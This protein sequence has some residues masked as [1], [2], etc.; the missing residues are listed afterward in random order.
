MKAHILFASLA[1]IVALGCAQLRAADVLPPGEAEAKARLNSSPRHGEWVDIAVPGSKTPLKSWIVYPEVKEKAPVVIVIH[2]IFG[3]SD[4]IRAVADQLAAEGFIAIAP[5]LLSGHGKDGGGTDS[6]AGRDDVTKAIRG[7]KTDEVMADLDAV[8]A[9]G[10]K[11]PASNGK[12]ACVGFCWGGGQ[13]FAYAAHQPELS[14]AVVYYGTPPA[15]E[16]L[17]KIKAPVLGNYGG[18]DARVTSTVEPTTTAMAKAK[19]SYAPHVYAGAG[20]G[21]LRA[22]DGQNG[23]NLKA[24]QEAWPLTIAF[25][26][27][28]T[29]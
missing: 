11:L 1:W 27:G 2:E 18:N 3:E 4:W 15:P 20:H 7:L 16:A 28:H 25:L 17:E 24:A 12:T 6:Y 21:F 29:K 19:K 5:D 8:R 9:Y 22:Q 26:K 10:M 14:A 23:A 13:S